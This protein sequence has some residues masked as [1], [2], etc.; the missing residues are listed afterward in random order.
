MFV[1]FMSFQPKQIFYSETLITLIIIIHEF[2]LQ[3]VCNKMMRDPYKTH[4]Y[5]KQSFLNYVQFCLFKRELVILFY[6]KASLD[7]SSVN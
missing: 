6:I 7:W 3:N 4:F 1:L 2:F 5:N